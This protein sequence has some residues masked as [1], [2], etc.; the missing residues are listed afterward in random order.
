L[1]LAV[2]VPILNAM[3]SDPIPSSASREEL[4]A[5]IDAL[6]HQVAQ[7]TAAN[8]TLRA[9]LDR[10]TRSG[11]SQATPFSKGSRVANPQKPGRKPG[12]GP[13]RYRA[14]P[15][16]E[17]LNAP[18]M[19]VPVPQTVCPSCGG[20]LAHDH[21]E[22]VT[23]TDLPK[24]PPPQITAYA[25]EVC[26]C[27]ACGRSVRGAHPAV[28]PDQRGASAHRFGPGVFATAHWLHYALGVPVRKVP[29]IL[30]HLT[31]IPLT[32]G[33]LTRDALRRAQGSV[34]EAYQRLRQQV[35]AAAV[36]HTDD[37][38]WKVGG[39]RE[40]LMAFETQEVSVY[41]IRPQHRNEEVRELIPSDYAGTMVTDRGRS[42]DAKELGS[43]QQQKCLA[44]I[45]RSA[46]QV[47]ERVRE[48]EHGFPRRLKELLTEAITLWH[49]NHEGEQADFE[50]K[51]AVLKAAISEHL[52]DRTVWDAENQRLQCELGRHHERG[53]LLRFLEDPRVPPTNNAAERA[54]RP[55]VIARKVSQC[56][57]NERGA[58]AYAAFVSVLRTLAKRGPDRLI[59]EVSHLFARA[60]SP[61]APEAGRPDG[62]PLPTT[63]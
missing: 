25:V 10:L 34:G 1:T 11:K 54:L 57:K 23:I 42:Y 33:A 63:H 26:C 6:Q 5:L 13:F 2:I 49:A 24:P 8:E 31:G 17:A 61:A 20:A 40:H 62:F 9:Q 32:Q 27:A 59:A 3:P 36:I 21:I 44:H 19:A 38:G 39:E 48:S 46:S 60:R 51:R 52:A 41:Q 50:A 16:V 4:L 15:P 18:P 29:A 7:L 35:R 45:L 56:S 58:E 22:V 28:A 47:M 43:V 12:K 53:N 30:A 37:T 14:A 55:A